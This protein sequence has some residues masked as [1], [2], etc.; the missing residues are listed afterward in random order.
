MTFW[1]KVLQLDRRWIYLAIVLA[2][3]VPILRPLNLPIQITNDVRGVYDEI[4]KLPEGSPVLISFDYEPASIPECDPQALAILRHCFSKN[5][6]VTGV[7]ILNVGVGTGQNVLHEAAAEY[8]KERGTDYTFLG[9]KG[10]GFS[11]VVGLGISVQDTFQTD[12][13]GNDTSALPVLEGVGKL[14]DFPYMVD[15]HDDTYI[16]TWVVYG[17]EQFG[18]RMGSACTAVLAPGIYPF[19][20][21]GQITGIVGALKGASEYEKL[22][23]RRDRAARGM[24]SQAIVHVFLVLVMILGNV[25]YLRTRRQSRRRR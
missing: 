8:G 25:A 6:R 4:E 7:T 11:P 24:D 13:Y 15:I 22:I 18:L 17:H 14:A 5:L 1:G 21:A 20:K 23:G 10:G 16:N 12:S 3:V 9:Y 2:V 19:L